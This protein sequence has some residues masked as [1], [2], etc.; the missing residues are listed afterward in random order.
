MILHPTL[1]NLFQMRMNQTKLKVLMKFHQRHQNEVEQKI[2]EV[3][4]N[5]TCYILVLFC[6]TL[7][8]FAIFYFV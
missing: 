2:N 4:C 6:N 1:T 8:S 5:T 3:K 7:D